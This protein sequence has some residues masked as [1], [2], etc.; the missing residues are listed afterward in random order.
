MR[1][2]LILGAVLV[3]AAAFGKGEDRTV[4]AFSAVHVSAGMR[5]SIEIGP[6]RPVHIEASEALLPLIETV[7]EEGTLQVRFKDH[8]G[9]FHDSEGVKLT[10]RTP[11]L[12]EVGAS[13]GS[14]VRAAFTRGQHSG[15]EASGGSEIRARG[16]DAGEFEAQASGGSILNLEGNADKVSLQLSGGS[17]LHGRDLSARDADVHGSGGSEV[18]L[19]ASGSIRGSL[20]GGSQLHVTGGASTRVAT[21]GG[22]EVSSD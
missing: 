12:H 5:A 18:E 19:K 11:E 14:I 9:F 15:I 6:Q 10:I 13:G 1:K 21:S 20:S 22:S 8:H 4:P 3:S 2:S 16:I 7:V 17:Q